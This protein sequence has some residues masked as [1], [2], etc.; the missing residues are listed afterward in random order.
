MIVNQTYKDIQQRSGVDLGSVIAVIDSFVSLVTEELRDG[1]EIQIDGFGIFS[2]RDQ[3]ARTFIIPKTGEKR[4]QP[5]KKKPVFKFDKQLVSQFQ[6]PDTNQQK[7][8]IVPPPPPSSDVPPPPPQASQSEKFWYVA[9]AGGKDPLKVPQSEIKKH[10]N[11][12][13]QVWRQETGW[14]RAGDV[15]ELAKLLK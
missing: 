2:T 5:A 1:R 10:A 14:K 6:E 13:T 9:I 12:D 15:P 4:Y 3:S 8:S 7:E 11:P